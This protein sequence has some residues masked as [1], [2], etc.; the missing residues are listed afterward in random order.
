MGLPATPV[1]LTGRQVGMGGAWAERGAAR[2]A[3][4]VPG[5]WRALLTERQ[6]AALSHADEPP[7]G[8]LWEPL[9]VATLGPT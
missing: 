6:A 1:K 3:G 9:P 7:A 8:A 4:L 2:R 5:G